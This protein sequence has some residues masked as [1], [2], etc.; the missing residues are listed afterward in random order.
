MVQTQVLLKK[1]SLTEIHQTLE[2][3]HLL[4]HVLHEQTKSAW[5]SFGDTFAN[6]GLVK[7]TKSVW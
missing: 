4:L 1:L 7:K 5:F 2:F 3:N 6:L